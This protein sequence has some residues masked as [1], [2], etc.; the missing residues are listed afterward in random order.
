MS[1][2]VDERSDGTRYNWLQL[3]SGYK[4]CELIM[5]LKH[6]CGNISD[7]VSGKMGGGRHSDGSSPKCYDIGVDTE[8]GDTR[9]RSEDKHPEYDSIDDGPGNATAQGVGLHG[10]W[11]G[12]DFIKRNM[13]NYVLCQAW[14]DAGNNEGSSPA[15]A[16]KLIGSW[17]VSDPY[18]PNPPS[19]HVETCRVDNVDCLDYKWP[20][21]RE[22]SPNDTTSPG[23]GGVGGGVGGGTVGGSTGSGQVPGGTIGGGGIG[24]STGGTGSYG[25]GGSTGTGSGGTGTGVDTPAEQ[26]TQVVYERKEFM[27]R[28]N[29]NFISG[30]AC[31]VGKNPETRPLKVIYDVDGNVYAEGKHYSR[32]G[33]FVAKESQTDPTKNSL[34]VRQTPR[35][36]DYV[37][38]RQGLVPLAGNIEYRIR[39]INYNI[40]AELGTTAA[41]IITNSDQTIPVSFPNNMRQLR[42]G[43]HLSIEYAGSSQTDFLRLKVSQTDELDTDNTVLFVYDGNAYIYDPFADFGGHVS[44]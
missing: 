25:G 10:S 22:I 1:M 36:M 27:M 15:N 18:W 20:S 11:V 24:G 42:K 21:L 43:D 23:T 44:V 6:G 7:E 38:K 37:A 17:N 41:S 8:N 9:I 29:L 5:Y 31:G 40:V 4:S 12:Y 35:F 13:N 39:D 3:G 14:Q 32:F 16:W 26:E 33:I 34:F 30:D 28:W 19:D 2:S